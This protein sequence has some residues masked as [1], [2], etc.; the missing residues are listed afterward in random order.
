MLPH[1]PTAPYYSITINTLIS[2]WQ[3][4]PSDLWFW[5]HHGFDQLFS[6]LAYFRGAAV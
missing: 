2:N 5:V 6:S 3:R 4:R 1:K